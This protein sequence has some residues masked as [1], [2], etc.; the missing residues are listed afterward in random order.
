LPGQVKPRLAEVEKKMSEYFAPGAFS[1]CA[2]ALKGFNS[3]NSRMDIGY[4]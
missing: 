2:P 4:E 3:A 1:S